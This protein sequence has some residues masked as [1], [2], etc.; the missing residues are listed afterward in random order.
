MSALVD[1]RRQIRPTMP[2]SGDEATGHDTEWVGHNPPVIPDMYGVSL[3]EGDWILPWNPRLPIEIDWSHQMQPRPTPTGSWVYVDY[4]S[5]SSS[6]GELDITAGDTP[7]A[8]FDVPQAIIDRLNDLVRLTSNWDGQGGSSVTESAVVALL[9][10]LRRAYLVGGDQLT[11]PFICPSQDGTLVAEWKTSAGKELILDVP[12]GNDPP[13]FLLVEPQI[14]GQEV[15]TD[16]EVGSR[17]PIEKVIFQL[18]AE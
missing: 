17:W 2:G 15:E 6:T 14:G 12:A 11:L 3:E 1:S 9:S 8:S 4:A 18:L 13:G 10:L 16:A 7:A 5:S